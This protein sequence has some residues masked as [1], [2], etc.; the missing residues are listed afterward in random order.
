M[1]YFVFSSGIF[2]RKYNFKRLY[3]LIRIASCGALAKHITQ[4]IKKLMTISNKTDF[5]LKSDVDSLPIRAYAHIQHT[6]RNR[7]LFPI[8]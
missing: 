7:I 5:Q 8:C 1:M 6:T 2:I 3:L 4:F